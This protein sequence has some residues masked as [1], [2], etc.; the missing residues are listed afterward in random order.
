MYIHIQL[1]ISDMSI[2]CSETM[3]REFY[4]KLKLRI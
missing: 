1:K 3:K 2:I 4:D